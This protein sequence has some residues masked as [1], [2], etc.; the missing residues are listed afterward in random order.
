MEPMKLAEKGSRNV[1]SSIN[2]D[3]CHGRSTNV[4]AT[5]TRGVSLA[6]VDCG[7]LSPYP[8]VVMVMITKYCDHTDACEQS[9]GGVDGELMSAYG[10]V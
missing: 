9:T 10:C 1:S 4:V 2:L 6:R 3:V 7:V 8:T 5:I